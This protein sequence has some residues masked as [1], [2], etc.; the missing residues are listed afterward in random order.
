MDKEYDF[1]INPKARSGM[2]MKAWQMIESEL[3]TRRIKYRAHL[4]KRRGHAAKSAELITSDD[5]EHT[6]VVLGGDGT[7]NEVINGIKRLERITFGYIPIGSSNDFARG[8]K[9]PKDPM[10]ALRFVLSPEKVISADVG[11]I[12][13][14][15]KSRRFIVSAGMGFDAGVCHEVCVSLW[16][17]RL[18][19]IGLGKLSY[20]VVALDRLKKD[21]PV[22]LT[23]TLPDGRKRTFE[24]TLFAAFMN[25]P[26][27]GGGFQ[28]APEASVTDGC[29]DIVVAHH[30]SPVKAV[31]LLPRA[32]FGKHAGAK[33]I[34]IIQ[35]P[36][37]SVEAEKSLPIHTDGEA[38]FSRYKVSVEIL[39]EKL[40]VIAG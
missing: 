14:E 10:E 38:V 17:K 34:T 32:L 1:I 24:K 4:T 39:E 26:Y 8:L 15:G 28:F 20:A 6:I 2:G 21:R 31:C 13:R 22:S 36:A 23:V 7:V 33:E 30:M 35:S 40:R 5:K 12:S 37:V 19:K 11:Q 9:L 27:E 16:K 18:N 3:K 29:I 25:L